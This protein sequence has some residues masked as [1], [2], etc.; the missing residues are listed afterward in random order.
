MVFWTTA[1]T[2]AQTNHS[3]GRPTLGK[4]HPP[5]KHSGHP[6]CTNNYV[7]KTGLLF[8][9]TRLTGTINPSKIYTSAT[10]HQKCTTW[11][12]ILI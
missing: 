6:F 9:E 10:L 4:L 5:T 2:N 7:Q 12:I 3:R 8:Y 1:A 11:Y